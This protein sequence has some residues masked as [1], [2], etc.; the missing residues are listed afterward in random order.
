MSV[1][2]PDLILVDRKTGVNPCCKSA[3]EWAHAGYSAVHQLA[4]D[5]RRARFVRSGTVDDDVAVRWQRGEM[6]VILAEVDKA[7][8]QVIADRIRQVI[9]ARTF[10]IGTTALRVPIMT[11]TPLLTLVMPLRNVPPSSVMPAVKRPLR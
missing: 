4:G 2:L 9:E 6:I 8:A 1:L 10:A 11:E 7:G 3:L 5:T